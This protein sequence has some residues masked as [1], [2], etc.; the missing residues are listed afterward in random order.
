[1]QQKTVD[2]LQ[3]SKPLDLRQWRQ[4]LD[5]F[6]G[7]LECHQYLKNNHLPQDVEEQKHLSGH[8][9]HELSLPLKARDQQL[10][11]GKDEM[12]QQ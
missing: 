9:Q 6:D 8:E 4:L 5:I 10:F 2:A 12:K 7:L 3:Q 1:L 11:C